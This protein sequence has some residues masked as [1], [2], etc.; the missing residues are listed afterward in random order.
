MENH[1][2][3]IAGRHQ[4]QLT[5]AF[6]ADAPEEDHARQA[7]LAALAAQRALELAGDARARVKIGIDTGEVIVR[8]SSNDTKEIDIR[9]APSRLAWRIVHDLLEGAVAATARTRSAAGDF[10]AVKPLDR[11]KITSFP[12]DQQI[13]EI[14]AE[15]PENG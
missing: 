6:G 1:G 12:G 4:F 8:R 10:I 5:A 3:V 15:N 2:G 9:G 7:C 14:L 13:F 11:A